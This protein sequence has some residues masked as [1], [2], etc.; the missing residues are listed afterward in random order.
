MGLSEVA[1]FPRQRLWTWS[2]S[3]ASVCLCLF[4]RHRARVG[5]LQPQGLEAPSLPDLRAPAS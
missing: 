3:P 5:Q 4:A 2:C 1:A